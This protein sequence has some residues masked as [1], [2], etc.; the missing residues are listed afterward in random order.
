MS[1]SIFDS[2]FVEDSQATELLKND[3][4]PSTVT[5]EQALLAQNIVTK[6]PTINASIL[7]GAVK[8]NISPDDPR[9]S[10]VI[11]RDSIIKEEEGKGALKSAGLYAKEKSKSGLR[12][13][14]FG[15]QALWEEGAPRAV[16]YLEA[17]QQGMSHEEASKASSASLFGAALEAKEAGR[18]IDL[19]EG[20][21]LGSTDPTQTEEYKNLVAS[22]VKPK[23]AREFVLNN[24]LGA[25]IY[26]QQRLKAETGVQFVGKRAEKFKEAGLDPTVTIGRYLFKPFDEIV[27][28][29]TGAYNFITGAIDVAAQIFL[30]P[31]ALITLGISKAGKTKKVFTSIEEMKKFENSGLIG[32]ARK[33]IHGPTTQQFLAGD[34]GLAFKKFLWENADNQSAIISRSNEKIKDTKFLTDLRKFKNNNKGK[35]FEQIDKSFTSFIDNHIIQLTNNNIPKINYK[36]NRMT[37]ML[38]KNYGPRINTQNVDDAMVQ[39]NRLLKLATSEMDTVKADKLM[40]TYMNKTLDALNSSDPS[41]EVTKNIVTFFQKDFK[42]AVVANLGGTINKKGVITGLS[43]SV[44]KLVDEGTS[45]MAAF[46]SDG[47]NYKSIGRKYAT[48]SKGNELPITNLVKK[49]LKK[50]LPGDATLVDPVVATQLASEI[51][52]PNPAKLARAAKALDGN[53]GAMG[54][55]YLA[56]QGPESVRRFMDWYYGGFF[57]PLVL[58]RPAWTLRVIAE[59]QVRLLSTG[60]TNI[61]TDPISFVARKITGGPQVE[62][63]LINSFANNAYHMEALS[64]TVGT[65]SSIRRRYAGAGTWSTINKGTNLTAWKEAAFRNVMQAYFDPMSKELASIQRLQGSARN[66]AMRALK[67]KANTQGSQLNKHIRKVT[68]AKDH[69][70]HGAGK[71]SNKGKALADE[72][73]NYVNANVAQVAG[74]FVETTTK[75]GATAASSRW[76]KETGKDE[77]LE[78]ISRKT[79]A[80]GKP[81]ADIDMSGLEKVDFKKYWQGELEDI[82]YNKITEQLAKNQQAVK[83][84]FFDKYL[85]LLPDT[86][87]AELFD[88]SKSIQ[89]FN[90]T[91]DKLYDML[92]TVPTNKLSRSPS[93][94]ANYWNKVSEAAQHATPA[95][96]KKIIKQAEK[97]GLPNG[98]AGERKAYKKLLSYKGDKDGI[99]NIE[100]IDKIGASYAL[101]ETKKI[102]YDVTTRTRLGQATRGLFPF[103]EAF[104]EIFTTWAKIIAQE[105]GRPLR[106]AQQLIQSGRKEN[107]V[108]DDE[109][110]KGF[111]YRDPLTNQELFGYPGEGLIRKWMFKDLEENGVKVNLPIYLQSINLAANV[112]PG[113]GPTIT[114]PAAFLN[115]KFKIFKP[116]GITQFVLFGD[117]SP[118]RAGTPGEI[119]SAL[120]PLPSWFKKF[121]TAFVQNSDETK[122]MFNNTVIETYKAL[123]LAGL[124]SDA[125]PE[126]AQKGL[127]L[128]AD[129]AQKIVLI[130]AASQFLGPSGIV[131]PKYEISDANGNFFLFETLA[132]EWRN[133][134]ATAPD[135]STALVEFTSRF[136]FDPI[137]L[138][139]A[140]TETIKKRPVTAEGAD[141]E[142]QNPDLVKKFDL[143]YGYLIDET[144]AEFSYDAYWNQLVEGERVP[145]TPEQWQRAKN[146]LK[147]NLEFEAWL[148]RNDLVNRTDKV[149]TQA[150]R[151]KKAELASKYYGYGLSIPGSVKKPEINE[152]I[153][154]LYTWF[155]P[156]TYELI[157][158]LKNESV[159]KALVEYVKER[160]KVIDATTKIPG[161][162]YLPTSFRSSSKLAPYRAHLRRVKSAILVKY[163]EA[164]GLLENVFERELREEYEDIELLKALNE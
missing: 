121:G 68:G 25:Q 82:E 62:V 106:R 117:F 154:E 91:V 26:E 40:K 37:K 84:D 53:L 70:F 73:I 59:E 36:G 103:G 22:G 116:E 32:A 129:Y 2:D 56:G 12:G 149:S 49:I 24:I 163:P 46:Y 99:K 78:F 31:T 143:T 17:R 136:G 41:T 139:T 108:F 14:F 133:I 115:E 109:A 162:S 42:P 83:K 146:I 39:M 147:G 55:K 81:F 118:P 157:S 134:E 54:T 19:G 101:D 151:N 102:L 16:R 126:E 47:G 128:A 51:Y 21:F 67:K 30:D 8:L 88:K 58:L 10:Q 164:E 33:T 45:V 77:L 140:K 9:L 160:D 137:T 89:V 75:A 44:Q 148:I 35:T 120:V 65:L 156:V 52:L 135:I 61:L 1:Y 50:D 130:R 105:R 63:G 79:G 95:T 131:T 142:R 152:I 48:D 28:P 29:G 124:A 112:I 110:N 104:V 85:D 127:D 94:R 111:F 69:M 18:E 60:V 114:V 119:L 113:F 66:N 27:E 161:E 150:K 100:I 23:D 74:G 159:A 141:W 4:T 93:F 64:D 57:K 20:L 98:K 5:K 125:S 34:A 145:R 144:D 71:A 76:I 153:S 6:Y 13:L 96:L 107:P 80:D 7:E 15:F 72:F 123:L 155:N 90:N 43:E 92:M 87:K 3:K 86:V 132:E 138:S 38:E 122:R 11:M 158:E 97:A